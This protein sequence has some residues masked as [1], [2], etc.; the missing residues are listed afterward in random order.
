MEPLLVICIDQLLPSFI[1]QLEG[2]DIT[3]DFFD[4]SNPDSTPGK[5]D[6]DSNNALVVVPRKHYFKY[7]RTLKA[8]KPV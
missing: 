8:Y 4:A 7:D 1:V 6:E 3:G 5:L 2:V